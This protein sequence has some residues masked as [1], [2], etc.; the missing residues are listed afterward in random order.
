MADK[1]KQHY[2][3]RFYLKNFSNNSDEKSI[4]IYNVEKN[5]FIPR[6]SLK[7]QAYRNYFYGKNKRIENQLQT[8]EGY[9]SSVI[10]DIIIKEL[11]PDNPSAEHK[12]LLVFTIFQWARVPY[13]ADTSDEMLN[14]FFKQIMKRNTPYGH[15]VDKISV[16]QTYSAANRALGE[17]ANALPLLYDLGCVLFINQTDTPFITSDNPVVLYNQFL[18]K[19]KELIYNTGLA[20]K[21]LQIFLPLSPK[22]YLL[23]FDEDVYFFPKV[24]NRVIKLKNK[25][26][27]DALNQLQCINSYS[28]LYFN[29]NVS[30]DTISGLFNKVKKYR[31]KN[32]A[33]VVETQPEEIS[34]DKFRSFI[35]A[36]REDVKINLALSFISIKKRAQRRKFGNK[37][38]TVRNEWLYKAYQH[39]SKQVRERKYAGTDFNK[40]LNE[41]YR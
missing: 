16:S 30:N 17:V 13:N 14:K 38:F 15:L 6:G 22:Y 26:D 39:F 4:G 12:T 3:P 41:H 21:G 24:R 25:L 32:K 35:L 18:E 7:D 29:E 8:I 40:F 5:L 1:K 11:L 36:Y 33:N 37:A 10:K 34:D 28:N 2:V 27:V 31:R 9:S 20:A 23:F 19:S